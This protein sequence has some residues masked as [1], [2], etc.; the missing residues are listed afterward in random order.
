MANLLM[1][2]L[3]G[4]AM[5]VRLLIWGPVFGPD[6]LVQYLAAGAGTVFYVA[7]LLA[8]VRVVRT[9]FDRADDRP[10]E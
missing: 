8:V 10:V 1:L 4:P 5:V 7:F 3:M 9:D 2:F 6:P